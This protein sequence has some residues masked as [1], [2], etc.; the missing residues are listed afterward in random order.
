MIP[1][2]PEPCQNYGRRLSAPSR[3]V[4]EP[5]LNGR[6]RKP[7]LI[8]VR[9]FLNAGGVF[10][11]FAKRVVAHAGC[12]PSPDAQYHSCFVGGRTHFFFVSASITKGDWL[13]EAAK[14]LARVHIL[15]IPG[16]AARRILKR[17]RLRPSGRSMTTW[18]RTRHWPSRWT[19]PSA[20]TSTTNGQRLFGWPWGLRHEGR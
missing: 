11:E 7:L 3:H 16:R 8:R 1:P 14:A 13:V 20:A 2:T 4:N 5:A 9:P 6:R 10:K 12:P 18:A 19:P 15:Q 17:S